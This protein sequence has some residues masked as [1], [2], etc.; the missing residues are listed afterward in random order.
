MDSLTLMLCHWLS[1]IRIPMR[2]WTFVEE[3]WS[4]YAQIFTYSCTL[5][6]MLSL[7]SFFSTFFYINTFSL[8]LHTILFSPFPCIAKLSPSSSSSWAELALILQNPR[9][10][11]RPPRIVVRR[12]NITKLKCVELNQDQMDRLNWKA[13]C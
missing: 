4:S 11:H 7:H 13:I 2:I 3:I 12:P 10:T 5:F 8:S 6:S 9:P 1:V